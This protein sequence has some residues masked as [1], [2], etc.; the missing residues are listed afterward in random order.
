MLPDKELEKKMAISIVRSLKER[1]GDE[2]VLAISLFMEKY[3]MT[4]SDESIKRIPI[5]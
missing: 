2:L 4:A 1:R 5:S 3:D